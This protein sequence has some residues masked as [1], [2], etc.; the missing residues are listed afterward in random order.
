[1]C[2]FVKHFKIISPCRTV[3]V[4]YMIC[5]SDLKKVSSFQTSPLT[6][7]A[8]PN[9]KA[10]KRN[11]IENLWHFVTWGFRNPMYIG[12]TNFIVIRNSVLPTFTISPPPL[13]G[14]TIVVMT[15]RTHINWHGHSD[16]WISLLPPMLT[17]SWGHH[18]MLRIQILVVKC[19]QLGLIA[20]HFTHLSH[21]FIS[22]IKF[23]KRLQAFR[24]NT[25]ILSIQACSFAISCNF[26]E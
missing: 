14:I 13:N 9:T 20:I 17:Y 24:L 5:F 16:I 18:S 11:C 1:M 8:S 19:L 26:L 6:C 21:L 23:I 22:P 25:K 15:N 12:G 4:E 2:S 10:L 3:F 7:E